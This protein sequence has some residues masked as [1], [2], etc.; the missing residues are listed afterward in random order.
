MRAVD[1]AQALAFTIDLVR[2]AGRIVLGLRGRRKLD[3]KERRNLVT[4][5]D[6]ASERHITAALRERFP[7]HA[8]FS[9]EETRDD[10]SARPYCWFIDP[11]DGTTNFYHGLPLFTVS[12]GLAHQGK[13]LLGVVHAPAL[14]ECY[15]ARRG[16]GAF[17]NGAP[18]RVSETAD[19]PDALL[20]SGFAY[21]RN[22]QSYTNLENFQRLLMESREVRRCGSAALDL[23]WVACGRFDGFWEAYLNPWDV[24]GGVCL[25]QEAGGRVSDFTGGND[26]LMGKNIIASNGKIHEA[27]REKL[28]P[29]PV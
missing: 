23:C 26:F 7:D 8:I 9:E 25:V 11:I 27:I 16:G 29:F 3:F 2:A 13:P 6:L 17:C 20:S 19:L 18:I 22:R 15:W 14:D 24:A 28:D 21:S 10:P 4:E 1:E 5:A 12:I